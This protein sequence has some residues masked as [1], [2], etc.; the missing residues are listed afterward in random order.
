MAMSKFAILEDNS[1]SKWKIA[2]AIGGA[3][4]VGAGI[5]YT[6]FRSPSTKKG[7]KADKKKSNKVSNGSGKSTQPPC[8]AYDKALLLK[9]E[10]NAKFRDGDQKGAIELYTQAIAECPKKFG[11]EISTF[12]QNRAAS[13]QKTNDWQNVLADCSKA[14]E[15]NPKYVKALVRRAKAADTLK[16]YDLALEDYTATCIIESFS[17][18]STLEEVDRLLKFI[19]TKHAEEQILKP[20]E[21]LPSFHAIEATIIGYTCD[22]VL[23]EVLTMRQQESQP[24]NDLSPYQL[25][26][27][28]MKDNKFDKVM[29]LLEKELN[30]EESKFLYETRY[31]R[32]FFFYL[33]NNREKCEEDLRFVIDSEASEK[34]RTAALIK[35]GT[36]LVAHND[37][38][39]GLKKYAEAANI[40]ANNADVYHQRG[41]AHLMTN[42]ITAAMEDFNKVVSL[43]P[44]FAI[45]HVQKLHT[46]Y[47]KA[48]AIPD[49]PKMMETV[50]EFKKLRKRFPKCQELVLLLSQ[51][52]VDELEFTEAES[53]LDDMASWS[54]NKAIMCVYKGM[55][56]LQWK[57]DLTKAQDL[58]NEAL[59][60][61]PQCEIA[62]E[63]LATIHVQS[64]RLDLGEKMFT[65]AIPLSRTFVEMSHYF[66]L[67]DAATAQLKVVKRLGINMGLPDSASIPA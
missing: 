27:H 40:D 5:Y 42:N 59:E 26:L 23:K 37:I 49:K 55:L 2:L 64:G 13:Y 30:I 48:S 43:D 39:G 21:K 31:L 18:K 24:S 36:I 65:K 20:R 34:L 58:M 28:A 4:V 15:L 63:N 3:V 1:T 10:G 52:L 8:E 67:R 60:I 56:A 62:L 11:Q 35:L 33:L 17:N 44:D 19:G 38:E 12:Y 16:N 32:G 9:N 53:L 7:S 41:Q 25:A 61:D 45:G 47:R 46:D 29:P 6:L 50:E 54:S 66:C 57:N 22:P 14:I 51:M